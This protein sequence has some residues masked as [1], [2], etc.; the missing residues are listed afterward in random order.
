MN[1][2]SWQ[3]L[4]D[5]LFLKHGA[6]Q[7]SCYR[8]RNLPRDSGLFPDKSM[9]TRD[10]DTRSNIEYVDIG[11]VIS[12]STAGAA[13]LDEWKWKRKLHSTQ[14]WSDGAW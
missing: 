10:T 7:T 13:A 5:T 1:E 11:G 14:A 3:K 9:Y 6:G 12:G 2:K 8:R 4:I